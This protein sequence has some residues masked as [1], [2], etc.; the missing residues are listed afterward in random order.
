MVTVPVSDPPQSIGEEPPRPHRRPHA[1]TSSWSARAT[2]GCPSPMRA[3]EVGFPVVGFDS[4]PAAVEALRAGRSYVED[5]DRR[6]AARRWPGPGYR[7]R[8]TTPTTS[9][10]STS[11]SS[12]CRRPLRDGVPD[13]SYIESAARDLGALPDGRARSSSSSRRPIRARPR[14]C[15]GPILE[16]SGL[17]AGRDFFLGY[18][19]ERIDPGNPTWTF[20]NTPEGRLRHRRRLAARGRGVLRR[21][22]RRRSCRSARTGR[23]RARQ[24]AREHVPP[25]Q[26]RARQR[27]RDVRRR[28]R[29]RHLVGDRRGVAPSRSATCASPRARASAATASRSTRRTS[30]GGSSAARP[31]VPLRRA[32]QRRQRAHARLRRRA[33]SPRC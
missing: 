11:R 8:P 22:G 15:C 27:A 17:R 16:E 9:P 20:E 29:R 2:S 23:G 30:R 5:V 14:S 24:A 13:L 3:V 1:P 32:R 33:G 25:R 31:P 7:R 6:A 18:S 26:H 28:P 10:A 4:T 21:A 12:R 19:P